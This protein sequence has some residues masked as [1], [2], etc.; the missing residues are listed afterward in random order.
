MELHR[1]AFDYV[2]SWRQTHG[3]GK[4]GVSR[5]SREARRSVSC[6]EQVGGVRNDE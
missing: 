1:F 2:A 4:E 3:K 6:S 5:W